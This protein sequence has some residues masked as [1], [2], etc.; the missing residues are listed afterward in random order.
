M[1]LSSL[2]RKIAFSLGINNQRKI[3]KLLSLKLYN[4]KSSLDKPFYSYSQFGE[5]SVIRKY[6]PENFG[7]YIDV[8]SGN[9]IRGNNTYAYY[10]LGWKGILIDPIS[11]NQILGKK[12]RQKDQIILAIVALENINLVNF[13]E[14]TPYEYSTMS[15]ER[16][17]HLMK[18][19]KNF[20][21]SYK[22]KSLSLASLGVK[23]T[24]NYPSF[25]SID[26]EGADLEV[27]KSNDFEFF[28]PR[29]ICIEDLGFKRKGISDIQAF[30]QGKGYEL[31]DITGPSY[32]YVT[33]F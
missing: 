13:F 27:L 14:F 25:L 31:K 22:V 23:M 5:D 4:S 19:G 2:F 33:S 9:P 26:A 16:Y 11:Q 1:K 28:R 8:G 29:V 3:Y 32:I 15:K 18:E 12:L 24:P 21:K 7:L 17:N 6:L 30:L 20:V 10:K